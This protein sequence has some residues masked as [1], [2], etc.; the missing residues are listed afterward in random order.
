M[1]YKGDTETTAAVEALAYRVRERDIAIRD[2]EDHADADVFALEFITAFRG[3]GWRPTE[4]R[5]FAATKPALPGTLPP[6]KPETTARLSDLKADMEARAAR[7]RAAR[8]S[9]R[10][11]EP[12]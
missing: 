3:R 10:E 6:L 12:A 5:V 2:G 11:D 7:D 4:A 8:E 9:A 1:T